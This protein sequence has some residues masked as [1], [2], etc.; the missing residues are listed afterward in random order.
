MNI[1]RV[2]DNAHPLKKRCIQLL[3]GFFIP[4]LVAWKYRLKVFALALPL[5]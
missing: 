4:L 1:T 3:F 2:M 5:I